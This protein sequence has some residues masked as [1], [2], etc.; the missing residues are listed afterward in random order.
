MRLAAKIAAVLV[1]GTVIGL[2]AT[3]TTVVR[4]GMPGGISDG[5]WR[6]SLAIGSPQSDPYTRASVA[7]HG[8]FALNRSEALYYTATRDSD[9]H[10]LDGHCRYQVSGRDPNARWWSIT[11]YGTDDFLIPNP[12]NRYSVSKTS[13]VRRADGT[14]I[15]DVGRNPGG[16]NGIAVAAQPFSLTLRLYNPGPE[17]VLDPADVDLPRIER[18]VCS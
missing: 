16:A 1:A 7:L 4:G 12:A 13:I 3:W 5:P 2:F 18:G 14:Y 15:V 6:T 10:R 17:I 9:G 8:L 11:A